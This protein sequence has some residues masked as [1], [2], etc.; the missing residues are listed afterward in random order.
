MN[1]NLSNVFDIKALREQ[2]ISLSSPVPDETGIEAT[3]REERAD[4]V[5]KAIENARSVLRL[6]ERLRHASDGRLNGVAFS[7]S[8]PH[9]IS[10]IVF[11]A[12]SEGPGLFLIDGSSDHIRDCLD[13]IV[14]AVE[15]VAGVARKA[16]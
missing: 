1:T 8:N 7:Q 6:V 12:G 10:D 13:S 11:F 14:I 2:L 15:M 5:A 4:M 16:A 3:R 9:E